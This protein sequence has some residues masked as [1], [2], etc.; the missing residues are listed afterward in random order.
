MADYA[1]TIDRIIAILR[2]DATLKTLVADWRFGELPEQH[3]GNIYPIVYVTTANSPEVQR[4]DLSPTQDDKFAI[5]QIITE[6]Y[7][8]I[9][10]S[11]KI[12]PEQAQRQVYN[13]RQ[14]V[15][16]VLSDNWPLKN[17]DG[18][19]AISDYTQIHSQPRLTMLNGHIVAAHTIMV[20]V[21]TH[22]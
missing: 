10:G 12:T 9:V 16:D 19:G 14:N 11:P 6:Y 21:T 1:A 22:E 2:N 4:K 5:Q 17:T 15:V 3:H 8:I 13:I 7:I 20:R 18:T